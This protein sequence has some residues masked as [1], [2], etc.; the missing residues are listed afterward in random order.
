M[1]KE[2]QVALE[3][4]KIIEEEIKLDLSE[5]NFIRKTKEEPKIEIIPPVEDVAQV[6]KPIEKPV[7]KK[8]ATSTPKVEPKVEKPEPVKV[9]APV[10]VKEQINETPKAQAVASGSVEVK[11]QKMKKPV[12]GSISKDFAK[13]KLVYSKTL[14]EW[15]THLGIDIAANEGTDVVAA[16]DGIVKQ[17]IKDERLGITIILDHGNGL[18]TIYKNIAT[19]KLVNTGQKVTTGQTIS[20]VS[21]GVG[22][23]KLEQP[24]LH[25][26]VLKSGV[27]IDPKSM[28]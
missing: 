22:F 7:E 21:K 8:Q 28:F 9:Q 18:E 1:N 4:S 16:L 13:D 25:F 20:K 23:E 5:K 26:E 11:T 24:H 19:E 3:K 10:A 14:E 12:Q 17:V 15:S 27:H 6:E 2:N